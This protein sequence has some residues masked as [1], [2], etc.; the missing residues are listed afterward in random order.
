MDDYKIYSE[1]HVHIHKSTAS[2]KYVNSLHYKICNTCTDPCIQKFLCLTSPINSIF[3][4]SSVVKLVVEGVHNKLRN[5]PILY[6]H[7]LAMYQMLPLLYSL[8]I[9][10]VKP[11]VT[12]VTTYQTTDQQ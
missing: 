12:M 6:I 4:N 10:T 11:T 3:C 2:Y 9:I 1:L 5:P 8:V 7:E